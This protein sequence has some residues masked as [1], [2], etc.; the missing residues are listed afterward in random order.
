MY[1]NS[2]HAAKSVL[3]GKIT[4][5][6]VQIKKEERPQ[7]VIYASTLSQKKKEKY[8]QSNL[9]TNT[10]KTEEKKIGP[11]EIIDKNGQNLP[12]LV[13]N[14]HANIYI[15]RFRKS[16]FKKTTLSSTQY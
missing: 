2:W 6:N 7:S 9:Q 15:Y 10:P 14:I 11:E 1:Y 5:F 12:N 8:T 13:N 3:R 16:V 4:A